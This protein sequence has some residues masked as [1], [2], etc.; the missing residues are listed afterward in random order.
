MS[1]GIEVA[2]VDESHSTIEMLTDTKGVIASLATSRWPHL[3]ASLCLRFVEPWGDAVFNQTQ[4]PVLLSELRSELAATENAKN[5][6]HL[7]R[8][9]QLVEKA[10]DQTH[11][12][13]KFVGELPNPSLHPKCYSRLRLLPPSR[14][15]KR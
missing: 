12:Y 6:E 4:L 11:T 14:E 2:W 15:L 7:S 8:V 10:Q 5:T 13:I 9:I 3:S 1:A